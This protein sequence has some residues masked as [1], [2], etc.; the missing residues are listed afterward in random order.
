MANKPYCITSQTDKQQHHSLMVIQLA[1]FN[2]PKS[3]NIIASI[4]FYKLIKGIVLQ[5]DMF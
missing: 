4:L 3:V 2:V 1:D 5:E